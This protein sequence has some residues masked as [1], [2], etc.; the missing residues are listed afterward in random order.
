MQIGGQTYKNHLD[1]YNQMDLITGKGPSARHEI[2]YFGE[3]QLGAIRIDDFKYQFYQQPFGWPGEKVTTDMPTII[4]L[5]QDPFERTPSIRGQTLNDLGGGYMNDFMAREFWR[6]VQVQQTVAAA[7]QSFIDY[8][9]MQQAAS[10]NLAAGQREDRGDDEGARRAV[11][12]ITN[13]GRAAQGAPAALCRDR[14]LTRCRNEIRRCFVWHQPPC[15]G[16]RFGV[17][18]GGAGSAVFDDGAGAGDAGRCA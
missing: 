15:A 16:F 18:A 6:F 10:F 7:A 8:P 17:A 5:R 11:S 1:G 9:P 14:E 13:G 3:S 4:N 2:F 12:L